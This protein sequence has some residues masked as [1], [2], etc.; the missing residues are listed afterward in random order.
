MQCACVLC[1]PNEF[2]LPMASDADGS[3]KGKVVI[4]EGWIHMLHLIQDRE[5]VPPSTEQKISVPQKTF[6]SRF[7]VGLSV[8]A[9]FRFILSV[10]VVTDDSLDLPNG[11]LWS[12][13]AASHLRLQMSE[14][15]NQSLRGEGGERKMGTVS[16]FAKS[17]S[18]FVVTWISPSSCV[19]SGDWKWHRCC[20]KKKTCSSILPTRRYW[21]TL[22]TMQLSKSSD[23]G[24]FRS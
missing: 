11:E 3:Q 24:S 16:I 8:R 10:L 13:F 1:A 22:R 21:G 18:S 7:S 5:E 12:L 17:R 2:L 23:K 19:G 9:L 6:A 14:C 4:N 20:F 15:R